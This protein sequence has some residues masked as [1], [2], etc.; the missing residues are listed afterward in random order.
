MIGR[1]THAACE[2]WPLS[3]G[4]GLCHRLRKLQ[5]SLGTKGCGLEQPKSAILTSSTDLKFAHLECSYL[6]LSAQAANS[7]IR[8]MLLAVNLRQK[9]TLLFVRQWLDAA[10]DLS[11]CCLRSWRPRCALATRW[12]LGFQMRLFLPVSASG[13]NRT[14]TAEG[15]FRSQWTTGGLRECRYIRPPTS[16]CVYFLSRSALWARFGVFG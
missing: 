3:H 7:A 8:S 9:L 13:D 11:V 5:P 4:V 15:H 16:C 1:S 14:A 12:R 6:R 2:L 10:H